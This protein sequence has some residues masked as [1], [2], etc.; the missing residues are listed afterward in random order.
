V[1]L[2]RRLRVPTPPSGWP[3][4]SF[5]T[6]QEAEAAV[7]YLVVHDFPANQITIVGVHAQLVEQG[8]S[9]RAVAASPQRLSRLALLCAPLLLGFSRALSGPQSGISVWALL[10]VLTV[11][12]ASVLVPQSR[13]RPRSRHFVAARYDVLSR[14][15]QAERAKR[16]LLDHVS[17]H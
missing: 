17:G 1:T 4:G 10:G 6:Y 16:M 2:L 5:A 9:R 11:L 12:A 3:I 14:P 15:P 8:W 13:A 7:R